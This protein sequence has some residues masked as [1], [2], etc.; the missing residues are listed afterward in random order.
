[1]L[2]GII[3]QNEQVVIG[4]D[5]HTKKHVVT[6]KTADGEYHRATHIHP[7]KAA[8]EEFLKKFPGCRIHIAYEAG[9]NGYALYDWIK[10][11]RKGTTGYI[12]VDVVPPAQVP[13]VPGK[14]NMKTD[15]RDSRDL[16]HAVELKSYDS[17]VVPDTRKRE[18]RQVL[19][20]RQ[21]LV[22]Q[23]TQ[24]ENQIHGAVKFHAIP[25]PEGNA[26]TKKW[27]LRLR[28][29]IAAADTTGCLRVA[30][31]A[32][33]SV[34]ETI[35][36]Q[37]AVLERQMKEIIKKGYCGEVA[38]KLK[39][40]TGIGDI[41]AAT[42]ATEVADFAAF[43]NSEAFAS[44]V[45][46][47][48]GE[49]SSGDHTRRG[50]ITRAGNSRLRR[51]LVECAWMWLR[52]DENARKE[53]YRIMAGKDERKYIAI[54]ALARKLAVKVYHRVVNGLPDQAAV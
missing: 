39:G 31:E 21:A 30:L 42:I 2:K 45:G 10:E 12:T 19:R 22:E 29:N 53:F 35:M 40:L 52:L 32:L 38:R 47:V 3:A 27:L 28:H 33:L 18:E 1:M 43:R 8:W 54:V 25:A 50:R 17:V 9:P 48:P 15:K 41:S 4:V 20:V 26:F 6:V 23:R 5:V 46:L 11:I 13:K 34:L 36:N 24:I 7:S 37:I 16:I 44:Y 51:V 49:F 14:K